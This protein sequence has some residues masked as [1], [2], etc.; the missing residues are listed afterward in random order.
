M[1]A[2]PDFDDVLKAQARIARQASHT[3]LVEFVELNARAGRR[4][5][6]KLE[7]LQRTG[8]F[9]FR[10]A[11]NL[12]SEIAAAEPGR[13]VVAYS[14]GNHAQAVAAAAA[15]CGLEATI[16]MPADAPAIKRERTARYGAGI[17]LYDRLTEDREAIARRIAEERDAAIVPP[18]DH[19]RIIAGQGTV[20]L[21]L[22]EEAERQGV[23]L[24]QV[25]VP[26]SGGGLIAG[27]ALAMAARVPEARIYAVEPAGFDDLARS[28]KSGRRERNAAAGGSI[29]DALLVRTP[30]EM[31]FK[32]NRRLL[33]GGLA[34]TD[35]EV[36]AAV[37]FG[38]NEL[39][40]VLE[41][42][43]AAGLAALLA[44]KVEVQGG[45]IAVVLT[46]GNVDPGLFAAIIAGERPS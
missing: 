33:A 31:T 26:A 16:V 38:F 40:L 2:L 11:Y 37:G 43:G 4:V 23:A 25:L 32:I 42:S 14:S 18:Y 12:V 45:D 35:E 3:P 15:L 7:N 9:K 27:I 28:L 8:S 24:S 13:P 6:L 46:S 22:A 41:P 1:Q 20:G 29:C 17:V 36:R 34:V 39:K 21:E 30:G 5:L 10:G 44:G 19:P